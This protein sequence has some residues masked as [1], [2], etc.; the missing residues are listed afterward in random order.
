MSKRIFDLIL[1]SLGLI[2][3][4]WLWVMIAIM[5]ILEDGF[6]FLIRQQRIGKNGILF[7]SYKF[8]S[9]KKHTLNEDVCPQ[10]V[11]HDPRFT[12]VGKCLRR[13]AFDELPQLINIFLGDMSF[14]GPRP[15]LPYEVETLTN[16]GCMD[17][18]LI[19][20]YEKR[21]RIKPGLTGIAQVYAPRDITRADKFRM[22][23]DY[24]EKHSFSLDAKLIMV[25][26]LVSFRGAWE[27]RDTKLTILKNG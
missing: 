14:V 12:S 17:V 10:A 8:R 24:I 7:E 13:T 27:R 2:G 5:I 26:F 22:D 3:S 21:I 16:G 20:G 6:P 4:A 15:I 19:P 23:I 9:M 18:R 1:S 11:E 25:S